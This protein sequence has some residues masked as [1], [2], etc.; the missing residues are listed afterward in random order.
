MNIDGFFHL[1]YVENSGVAFGMLQ[2]KRIIFVTMSLLI[3]FV[4]AMYFYKAND[5]FH[6]CHSSELSAKGEWKKKASL[7]IKCV[8]T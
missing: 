6:H 4:L 5:T 1:T 8:S 7:P 2:D 3:L